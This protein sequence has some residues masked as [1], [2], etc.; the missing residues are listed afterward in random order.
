MSGAP[1]TTVVRLP[2]SVVD[3]ARRW[4]PLLADA[5][6]PGDALATAW[7]E[8]LDRH[9]SELDRAEDGARVNRKS[10][11][12]RARRPRPDGGPDGGKTYA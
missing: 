9:D 3:E 6:T 4:G 1:E 8:Y 11:A 2:E 10:M 7:Y 5:K 12:K